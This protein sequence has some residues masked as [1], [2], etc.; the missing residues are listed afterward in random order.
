MAALSLT[1]AEL[2]GQLVGQGATGAPLQGLGDAF[3]AS[4]PVEVRQGLQRHLHRLR[5]GPRGLSEENGLWKTYC[6]ARNCRRAVAGRAGSS[7]PA[8]RTVPP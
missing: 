1:A 8:S 4:L 2:V 7:R 5:D 3:A 6:R